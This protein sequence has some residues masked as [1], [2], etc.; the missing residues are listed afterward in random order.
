VQANYLDLLPMI[1]SPPTTCMEC[2][3]IIGCFRTGKL[4]TQWVA[5]IREFLRQAGHRLK[6]IFQPEE[7]EVGRA[8]VQAWLARSTKERTYP[9]PPKKMET[10]ASSSET[11]AETFA[12]TEAC[13]GARSAPAY[14]Y[15]AQILKTN[16]SRFTIY[17]LCSLNHRANA[18]SC[19]VKPD[20][21]P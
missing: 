18:C 8:R 2:P 12:H 3:Y 1:I 5:L 10:I 13:A 4:G 7:L 19:L 21:K 11:K 9:P 16:L 14:M 17:K 20:P 15:Q 6:T